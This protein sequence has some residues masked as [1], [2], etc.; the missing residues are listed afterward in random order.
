MMTHSIPVRARGFAMFGAGLA[1]AFLGLGLWGCAPNSM[2]VVRETSRAWDSDNYVPATDPR[3]FRKNAARVLSKPEVPQQRVMTVGSRTAVV[4]TEPSVHSTAVG[5]LKSGDAVRVTMAAD[6]VRI[7][8][9]GNPLLSAGDMREYVGYDGDGKAQ[10]LTPSWVAVDTGSVKGWVPA[11]ALIDPIATA[12]A[13]SSMTLAREAASEGTSAKGF[14]EKMKVKSTAMKGGMGDVQLKVANEEAATTLLARCEA[15]MDLHVARHPSFS[16]VPRLQSLPQVG[17]PLYEVDPELAIKVSEAAMDAAMGGAIGEAAKT[18]SDGL[19]AL[20]QFGGSGASDFQQLAEAARALAPLL[21]A[22]P[23]TAEEERIISKQCLAQTVGSTATLSADHPLSAYV[24]WVAAWVAA[25]STLP[26]PASGLDVVVLVDPS[27]LNAM[28]VPGGPILITTGMLAFLESED[29]LAFLLA[30]E[31]AHIE[32]RHGF[33]QLNDSK[34]VRQLAS[35]VSLRSLAA[36]GKLDPLLNKALDGV[37]GLPAEL[38]GQAMS[39]FKSEVDKLFPAIMDAIVDEIVAKQMAGADQGI[40]TAADLRGLSLAAA[41][42]YNPAA[43]EALLGRMNDFR[44]DY[45]GAKYSSNRLEEARAMI[46]K[47]PSRDGG[48]CKTLEQQ[49]GTIAVSKRAQDNWAQV[50]SHLSQL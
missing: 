39:R 5:L 47:L 42:G 2:E 6:F 50:R 34:L 13:T 44:G 16:P 36:S 9:D 18:A 15:P 22:Y 19:S 41:A 43:A 37:D 21:A 20:S 46:P 10:V 17:R 40:E 35:A 38:R 26:Y 31:M 30:H 7:A 14:S 32:E 1:S 27:T 24:N 4:F 12:T 25:Q 11:R 3:G 29:E 8:P 45:G 33:K 49:G 48:M 23:L 28:A